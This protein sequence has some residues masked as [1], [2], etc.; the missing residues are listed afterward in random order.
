MSDKPVTNP[1]NHHEMGPST[2]KGFA[3]QCVKCGALDTEIRF[4]LGQNCSG[5]PKPAIEA[6]RPKVTKAAPARTK[7]VD[8]NALSWIEYVTLMQANWFV[9]YHRRQMVRASHG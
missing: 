4:G 7:A 2:V 8:L 3:Q 6:P 5:S 1:N 9:G